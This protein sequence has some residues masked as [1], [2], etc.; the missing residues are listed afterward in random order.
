MKRGMSGARSDVTSRPNQLG[1]PRLIGKSVSMSENVR[2]CFENLIGRAAGDGYCVWPEQLG[3]LGAACRS[4]SP[5]AVSN[6]AIETWG[7][8]GAHTRQR[9][10]FLERRLSQKLVLFLGGVALDLRGINFG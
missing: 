2:L 1:F 4:E 5:L 9:D 6:T 3:A 10:E 8:Y 7:V